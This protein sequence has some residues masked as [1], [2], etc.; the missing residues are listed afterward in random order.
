MSHHPVDV[1]VGN[2]LRER[3]NFLRVSQEKLGK[4]LGLTFQQIQKYEKGANRVGASRLFEISQLLRVP[5]SYFFE[6]MPENIHLT[7]GA[8]ADT[9]GAFVAHPFDKR[10]TQQLTRAYYSIPDE[11]TRKRVLEL[12]KAIGDHDV[13]GHND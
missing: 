1:H 11:E 2:R 6:D 9:N 3:R 4:D 7:N 10:E 12:I 8:V 13:E 5:T